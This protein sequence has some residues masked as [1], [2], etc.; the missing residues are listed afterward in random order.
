MR[1]TFDLTGSV[2]RGSRR[3]AHRRSSFTELDLWGGKLGRSAAPHRRE[4]S[5][6]TPKNL[7]FNPNF[8]L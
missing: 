2:V 6:F 7:K 8:V 4:D 5:Q 1:V 3:V